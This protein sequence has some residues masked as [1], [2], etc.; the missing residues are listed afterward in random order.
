[1]SVDIDIYMRNIIKFFKDNPNELLS[2]IPKNKEDIFYERI[3]EI[4][5]LN[6]NN[7]SEVSL[8][9]KQLLDLCVELNNNKK[10]EKIFQTTKFGDLCLN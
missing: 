1:M 5:T 10:T 9:K 2:L 7:G 3:K 8:T 6:I 4:A